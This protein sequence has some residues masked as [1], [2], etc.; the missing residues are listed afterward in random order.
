MLCVYTGNQPISKTNSNSGD[1]LANVIASQFIDKTQN[2]HN[3]EVESA[4]QFDDPPMY[5]VIKWIG[6]IPD[7]GEIVQ[8]GVKMVSF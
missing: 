8:A 2:P 5:G 3:L 7:F 1:K 6:T 4:I